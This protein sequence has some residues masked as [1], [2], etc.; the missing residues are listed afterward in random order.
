MEEFSTLINTSRPIS[1]EAEQV[2]GIKQ[3]M[4]AGQPKAVEIMPKLLEF[5]RDGILVAHNAK[6]DLAFL[7]Y[8]F[9]RQR[10][11][12]NNRHVCTLEM[13]WELLP[14]LSN[15]K[16][17]NVYKHFYGKLPAKSR[18]HRALNDARMVASIW[19]AM[20]GSR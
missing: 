8:K 15:H 3:E 6:F 18:R 10:L 11:C 12:I 17:D 19:L 9:H 4:L 13:S 7:R 5:I 16:L 14:H 2:H 20:E 1:R